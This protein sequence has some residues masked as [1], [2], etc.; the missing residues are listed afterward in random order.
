MASTRFKEA[1]EPVPFNEYPRVLLGMDNGKRVFQ[2][3][4]ASK[5]LWRIDS[6]SVYRCSYGLKLGLVD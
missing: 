1:I 4:K 5:V 3:N 2:V 6:L